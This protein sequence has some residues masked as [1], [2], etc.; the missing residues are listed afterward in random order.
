MQAVC[1]LIAKL[2]KPLL[3]MLQM[4]VAYSIIVQVRKVMFLVIMVLQMARLI[5]VQLAYLVLQIKG[6]QVVYL[7]IA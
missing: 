6:L 2:D 7:L 4:Q 3:V 5:T 1:L